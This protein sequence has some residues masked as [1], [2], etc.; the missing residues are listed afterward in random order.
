MSEQM[1]ENSKKQ[2]I[3]ELLKQALGFYKNPEYIE[4]CL[5]EADVRSSI[6]LTAAVIGMEIWMLIRYCLK[7]VLTGR[8]ATLGIF[9][10]YTYTY[11]I[12]LISS[13]LLLYYGVQ[14]MKGKMGVLRKFSRALIFLYFLIGINFGIRTSLKDFS[15]GKM[16]ICFLSMSMYVTF[17]FVVRPYISLFLMGL[18]GV[19]FIWLI[20]M[21]AVDKEGNHVVMESGDLINYITFF[22]ILTVLYMTIYFQRYSDAQKEYKLMLASITDDLTGAPNMMR[23]EEL[24]GKYID[25]CYEDVRIPTYLVFNIKNF[26][27]FNDRFGH[28]KGDDLLREMAK[29]ISDVFRGEPYAR[30]SADKFMVLTGCENYE[31]KAKIVRDRLV[32]AHPNET[33]IDVTVG[34]YSLR[35][36]HFGPQHAMDRARYA[37][38]LNKN[39]EEFHIAEYDDKCRESYEIRHFI[40]NSL[41]NAVKNGYIKAF[42]QPVMDAEDGGICGCEALARWIDPEM[43]F[44]SPGQFIPILEESRQIHKLDKCIYESVFKRLRESMDAGLP[45]FPVSL[46]FSRLDFE[47]M[48]AVDELEQLIKKYDIPKHFIHVE[49]TESALTEDEAG[50]H[51]AVD[52]LHEKG[53]VVWLDDF[54]SGYSSMNVLKDFNF[55]L[56]KIDMVFLKGFAGNANSKPIIKTI[57]QLANRLHMETLTEGVET[58]EAVEFLKEA[59]CERLQGYYYGKPQTYEEILEKINNGT[60][61]LS[62]SLKKSE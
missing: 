39:T 5:R 54:G 30:H 6:I 29:I 36:S 3:G 58:G 43:G 4:D 16:I 42:Y 28:K 44:L 25:E 47:L 38:K 14:Y 13:I 24:S 35:N 31:E 34:A 46:N 37:M 22:I 20:D 57:I 7:Y 32:N 53:Y 62:E 55:D 45:V 11:W 60:Y 40:L 50:L 15:R 12:L 51:K 1:G 10:K 52:E 8:C 49:I 19:G 23:L 59:G 26:Q 9:F 2:G 48:D 18:S 21:Y 27:T 61:K 56:L 41:E 17:I 33:Y